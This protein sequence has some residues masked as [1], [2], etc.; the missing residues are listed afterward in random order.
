[1]RSTTDRHLLLTSWPRGAASVL[2][3]S[4]PPNLHFHS[5]VSTGGLLSLVLGSGGSDEVNER[6]TQFFTSQPLKT[7][8]QTSPG[9]LAFVHSHVVV[10]LGAR[11]PLPSRYG[12][13]GQVDE[14]PCGCRPQGREPLCTL[15]ICE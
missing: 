6:I 1:M 14:Q 10:F 15:V 8:P 7:R 5:G 9:G 11:G 3:L 13:I 12:V 4:G 2:C